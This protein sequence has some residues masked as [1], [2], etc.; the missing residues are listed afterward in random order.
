MV[1][2]TGWMIDDPLGISTWSNRGWEALISRLET[3]VPQ[4]RE[5]GARLVFRPHV[6]TI[7]SDV[8]RCIVLSSKFDEPTLSIACDPF[9]L[10]T[11]EMLDARPDHIRRA[12]E[13]LSSHARIGAL[14]VPPSEDLDPL[15]QPTR[16]QIE[17]GAQRLAEVPV[18]TSSLRTVQNDLS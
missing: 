6:A 11:E 9:A 1:L 13:G 5:L 16:D 2:W 12:F 18:L 3:L 17:A 4:A 14:V 15:D 8:Q 7:L 10:L